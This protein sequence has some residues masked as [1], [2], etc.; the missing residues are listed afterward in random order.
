MKTMNIRL[1]RKWSDFE[2]GDVVKVSAAKGKSMIAKNYGEQDKSA[3]AKKIA[4]SEKLGPAPR[5]RA[6]ETAD[7]PVVAE[8][9][10]ATPDVAG[11]PAPP[12]DPAEA[13]KGGDK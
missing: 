9:A 12:E 1:T 10:V 4:R 3:A 13:A 11:K 7:K 8:T 6:V 2:A 5:P